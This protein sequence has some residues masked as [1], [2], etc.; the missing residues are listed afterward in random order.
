MNRKPSSELTIRGPVLFFQ[1]Q[2][3]CSPPPPPSQSQETWVLAPVPSL[4][5]YTTQQNVTNLF[6]ALVASSKKEN[7]ETLPSPSTELM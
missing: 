2:N 3:R 1:K 4:A 5:S 6:R 7:R